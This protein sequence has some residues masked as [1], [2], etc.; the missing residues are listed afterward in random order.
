MPAVRFR[1]RLMFFFMTVVAAVAGAVHFVRHFDD[2]LATIAVSSDTT[3]VFTRDVALELTAAALRRV[4]LEPMDP[5]PYTSN[6]Q[7]PERFVGRNSLRPR[8][9]VSVI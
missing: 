5:Q 1:L 3:V 9:D 4:G 2:P 8:D 6:E 7:D